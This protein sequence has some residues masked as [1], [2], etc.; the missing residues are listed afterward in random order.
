MAFKISA[1]T[2][3]VPYDFWSQAG[4]SDGG[5]DCIKDPATPCQRVYKDALVDAW[6]DISQ[7]DIE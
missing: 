2:G 7:V 5:V 3:D 6:E 4:A 1:G